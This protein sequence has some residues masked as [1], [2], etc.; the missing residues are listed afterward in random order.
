MI[1]KCPICKQAIHGEIG[2]HW[3]KESG[4]DNVY[5]NNITM[6][7]CTCGVSIPSIFRSAHL[8]DLIAETLITKT[9]LLNGKEIR[10]LRKNIYLPSKDFAKKLGIEKTTLSKWENDTQQHRES[11]DRFI[12]SLYLIYKGINKDTFKIF[13]RIQIKKTDMNYIIIA[14]KEGNDYVVNYRPVLEGQGQKLQTVWKFS[15]EIISAI[16]G[17]SNIVLGLS[18]TKS[19]KMF[20]SPETISTWTDYRKVKCHEESQNSST[21]L[22]AMI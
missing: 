12:R 8:D 11:Y 15:K 13:D 22:F 7:N 2:N 4:L 21:L 20:S 9:A 18:Q 5:L 17:R 10:F 19:N 1:I 3:Y 14:E 16:A 6:Y